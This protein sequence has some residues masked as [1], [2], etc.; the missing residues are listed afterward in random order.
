MNI[1]TSLVGNPLYNFGKKLMFA[2]L[3][4]LGLVHMFRRN[5]R[6]KVLVLIYHDVLPPGFPEH[7]PLF[8]MTVSTTEFEWQ[9][10][11]VR[12]HYNPITFQQ[13]AD[14]FF[15]N[16]DLPPYPVLITFDDGHA[17]NFDFA[18]PILLK[19]N[20]SA[21][22]FVLSGNLGREQLTWFEDAYHRLMFSPTNNWKLTSGEML[23]LATA[24]QRATAC[25][26]FFVLCR[27]LKQS[28]QAEELKS[29]REQ[30]PLDPSREFPARFRFLSSAEL[31]CLR[32]SGVEIGAHTVTHP[33]LSTLTYEAAKHEVQESKA[34]LEQSSGL[35]IRAFAYP[36][37][38]PGLDF[39]RRERDLA[40]QSGFL[41][42]FAGEG[43]FVDRTKD[44]FNLPRI[45]MG[46]MTRHQFAATITGATDS[47]KA[48]FRRGP[49]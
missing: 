32:Q 36:F 25:G 31:R 12:K 34:Q 39:A 45:G 26:R 21:V 43:G 28:E 47:L 27:T 1:T 10:G 4:R 38:A 2:G 48:L 33:I 7:N 24:K 46:T 23:P 5:R 16:S 22:C 8:G 49:D 17:N 15:K 18:L 35:P 42:A 6:D 29:L 13:F 44:P 3:F 30:L 41:F 37:G 11:Y 14:W 19:F 20:I 40:R 9:L